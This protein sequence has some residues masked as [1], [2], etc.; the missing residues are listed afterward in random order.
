MSRRKIKK[1]KTACDIFFENELL[2]KEKEF[3]DMV[4][5]QDGFPFDS[6]SWEANFMGGNDKYVD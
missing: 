3:L 1:R 5:K 2:K 6:N 4:S